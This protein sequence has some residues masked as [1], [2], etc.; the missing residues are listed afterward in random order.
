MLKNIIIENNKVIH[1]KGF[2]TLTKEELIAAK[3]YGIPY[4]QR[5]FKEKYSPKNWAA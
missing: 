5:L 1:S 2:F 3:I 4:I